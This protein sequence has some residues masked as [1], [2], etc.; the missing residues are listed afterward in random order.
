MRKIIFILLTLIFTVFTV[1]ATHNRAGE[2]T[3]RQLSAY[4]F[5]FTVT[6]L[7]YTLS[8][9]DRNELEIT[10]GD[11][12]SSIAPRVAINN[13]LPDY[14]RKN[15]YKTNHTF[16]GP[17]IY[18][19]V[20][21]DPNRNF[22][23]LNIP[24]SVN[25]LFAIKT[26][27]IVNPQL[28]TNN[29][30]VLLNDPR[31][32]AA[33]GQVFIHNPAAFDPDGDSISYKLAT[34]LRDGGKPIENYSLPR[35]V[36]KGDTLFVNPVTGDLVWN[37]PRD[38]G[39]FNI[40]MNI[41]EWRK[42]VK[43]SNIVRDMQIEVH[44]SD[45]KP[46]LNPPLKPWCVE[47]G[48]T[49]K[50]NIKS[51]DPN[52]DNV[53]QFASGGPF[54]VSSPATFKLDSA[55][56]GK[57]YSTS[58]FTWKTN[59][60]HVRKQPYI[61]VIKAEDIN[62]QLRLT[63]TDNFT[64]MV[65]SPAP[66][67]LKASGSNNSIILRWSKNS[68]TNAS[69]YAIYRASSPTSLVIDS[70]VGGIPANSEYKKI[71]II[72]S[73]NDTSYVDNN[74]GTG[75]NLGVNY[76]Y[77]IVATF[78]DGA[79]SYPS[80]ETCATLI[81]GTPAL[82]SASVIKVDAANG[83]VFV[84]WIKPI[85]LDTIPA[86]GPY[87]YRIYRTDNFSGNNYALILTRESIDLMDTTFTDAGLNTIKYPYSYKIEL[88]N[89]TPGNRFMIGRAETASTMY[90]NLLPSDN[91][92]TIQFAKSV[93]WVDKRY[94]IYRKNLLT[95]K[96]DSIGYT[97][98]EEFVNKGLANGQSVS[99][100]VKAYGT[101]L[102]NGQTF[103]TLNWSHINS[104]IPLDTIKPCQPP[105][106]ISSSCDTNI[107][108]ITWRNPNLLCANDIVKYNVYYKP[109]LNDK[110]ILIATIDNAK[111]TVF[112]HNPGETLAG[113]YSVTAIDSFNNESRI[114]NE[115]CADICTGYALPNVFTPNDDQVNDKYI[116]YNPNHYVKQ[117]DMKIFNRWG[118]LVFR[119]SDPD[120]NWDGRDKET[121]QYV[122]TGVYY[123]LCDVYE[124]K[125]AGIEV[126]NMTG[127]IHVYSE[128][129]KPIAK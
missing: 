115:R 53:N 119:T 85:K 102:L 68:C 10:W 82:T 61:V 89:N 94:I 100:Q 32:K 21:Q 30:P 27:M 14:Y 15:T 6:T 23:V 59:C 54:E 117:V 56:S 28:G 103:K 55:N 121:K 75:L 79:L 17:G 90:P 77:R 88:Y 73:I 84:S 9:A 31:D 86:L 46:P 97:E 62:P 25:V 18:E 114:I 66:K 129:G 11:N 78:V 122:S 34:C 76:C 51:T 44:N 37:A 4:T 83:E 58:L 22:G 116:S 60:N 87:E 48:T 64:I 5:E 52:N 8:A 12:S 13:N 24:N 43:I 42:G 72:K 74:Q 96:F 70:C 126:R 47:A 36:V 95:E 39:I 57:G 112:N 20:M 118:K 105:F 111:D 1:K 125:L 71:G 2:I 35:K 69:G 26:T 50:F 29:T 123:Y 33:L 101:R 128:Q 67:N 49:I 108:I 93:P 19:I 104:T 38:T 98:T 109:G 45:N 63:D 99:Y 41:E 113:C 107:N 65:L 7:T 91:Q 16:P 110:F 127:F 92:V 80:D 120:I 124:P 81:P 106:T 40:A 3:Y